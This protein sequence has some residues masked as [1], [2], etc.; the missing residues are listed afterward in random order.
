MALPRP[1]HYIVVE[2]FR[3][4]ST[5]G[6]HGPVHVRPAPHQRFPQDLMVECSKELVDTARYPVGTRFRLKVKLTDRDDGREYL[7]SSYKWAYDVVDDAESVHVHP[8]KARVTTAG[9]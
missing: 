7:Y 4:S 1:Y 2:T 9:T 3:P 6:L 8:S 5:A